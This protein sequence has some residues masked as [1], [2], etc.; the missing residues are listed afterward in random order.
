[1]AVQARENSPVAGAARKTSSKIIEELQASPGNFAFVRAVDIASQY[2]RERASTVADDTLRY[3][4]NPSL[5]FPPGDIEH[6]QFEFP[7]DGPPRINMMLNLLGLHGAGSPLPAYFTE[8]VAQN[9]DDP[10]PLRE[11]FDMFNHRLISLLFAIWGKYRYYA[12]YEAGARDLLSRRFFG[13]IGAGLDETRAAKEIQWPRLMAYMGLIALNGEATGSLESILRHY[14]RHSEVTIIPCIPRWV[15]IPED[16]QTKLGEQNR[17]LGEDFIL[18]DV[19]RDQT[20]K[21]RIRIG[22]LS[23]EAFL[24]FLPCNDKFSELKAVVDFVLKS[25]FSFDVEL[26]LKPDEIRPWIL[27]DDKDETLLGWS[28]WCDSGGNGVVVLETDYGEL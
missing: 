6:L 27:G 5:A 7:E 16:Q 25:R 20:G 3:S 9:R 24:S 13:F 15:R 4:V 23:W 10:D 8:Y 2:V 11:F 17:S 12:Q 19:I 18:G 28:T 1:M 26:R 21:F 22:N 14:F